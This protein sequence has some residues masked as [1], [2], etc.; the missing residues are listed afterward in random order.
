MRVGVT[1]YNTLKTGGTEKRGGK[2]KFLIGEE[3]SWVKGWVP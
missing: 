1:V 2:T 3:E